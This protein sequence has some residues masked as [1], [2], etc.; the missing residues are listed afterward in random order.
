MI[1]EYLLAND[2]K[3]TDMTEAMITEATNC[4][5]ATVRQK[6]KRMRDLHMVWN[7][8]VH[9]HCHQDMLNNLDEKA[10]DLGVEGALER[11]H[12]RNYAERQNYLGLRFRREY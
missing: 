4:C 6:L 2:G 3:D 10:L 12:K 1:A 11:K 7:E 5:K 8:G 9:W